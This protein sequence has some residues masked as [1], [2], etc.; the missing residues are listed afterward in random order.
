SYF[1]K[2]IATRAVL[3]GVFLEELYCGCI[4]GVFDD[5]DEVLCCGDGSGFVAGFHGF[6]FYGCGALFGFGWC[7]FDWFLS[8]LTV[9]VP[10]SVRICGSA[11]W[12]GG[13][14]NSVFSLSSRIVR[15]TGDPCT[16]KTSN[17]K[18]TKDTTNS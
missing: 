16:E 3:E 10:V 14:V 8:A 11:S 5:F 18:D 4:H 17:N 7:V 9:T 1:N 15:A 2:I 12:R 13:G 6:G